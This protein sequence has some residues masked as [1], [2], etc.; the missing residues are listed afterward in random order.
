MAFNL[1]SSDN[2][3]YVYAL[4]DP[5]D[6]AIFYIG[7]GKGSR[8][9][10]HMNQKLTPK[11]NIRKYIRINEIK[12]L[13]LS[14]KTEA[15]GTYLDENTAFEIERIIIYKLGREAFLEGKL[16]NYTPGG[17]WNKGDSLY[18]SEEENTDF[19]V[20]SLDFVS[21]ENLLS[22][23]KISNITHLNDL[24]FK[25]IY[26][27]YVRSNYPVQLISI[28]S[29]DCFFRNEKYDVTVLFLKLQIPLLSQYSL[30]SQHLIKDVYIS[31]HVPYYRCQYYEAVFYRQLDDKIESGMERFSIISDTVKE[32]SA[33]YSDSCLI[34]K[35]DFGNEVIS[36]Y[37]YNYDGKFHNHKKIHYS[38]PKNIPKVYYNEEQL[39]SSVLTPE[40]IKERDAASR[41]W[42]IHM[43][44]ENIKD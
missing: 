22:I 33:T 13:G 7:K 43:S 8:L 28:D 27:Y 9:K 42:A 26:K 1:T 29:N 19:D 34:L 25:C 21:A 5:R 14:V 4:I 23:K 11:N 39:K 16:T 36:E 38:D 12:A 35:S 30:F 20:H 17:R 40:D 31:K 2:N 32:L 10:Q 37:F 18:Y 44:G 24:P 41:D 15:L 6:D 3:F